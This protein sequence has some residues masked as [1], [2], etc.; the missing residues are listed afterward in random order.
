MYSVL[1]LIH[2][3]AV[4][5][6]MG[7][8]VTGVFWKMH[9]DES[10][11]PRIIAHA[12]EGLIRSDRWFTIP[13]IVVLTLA[14]IATAVVGHLPLLHTPW[15]WQSLVLFSLAGVMFGV[16]LAPL[17][18]QLFKMARA[19]AAG[20]P[21]DWDRYRALSRQWGWWGAWATLAPAG[22]VVLM[23]TKPG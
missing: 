1:K 18:K 8:I 21:M 13:A 5:L 7:N 15:I 19:A 14:G 11:D 10:H 20:E 4:M 17:Q 6:F 22:A 12:L 2:V 16:W 9:A 23:I 3:V